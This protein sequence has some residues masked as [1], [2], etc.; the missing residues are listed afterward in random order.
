[1]VLILKEHT[2][3]DVLPSSIRQIRRLVGQKAGIPCDHTFQAGL[4]QLYTIAGFPN[5][6]SSAAKALKKCEEEFGEVGGVSGVLYPR[7]F[8]KI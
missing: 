4:L 2:Q 7:N 6:C 1:M 8:L 3:T 5:H